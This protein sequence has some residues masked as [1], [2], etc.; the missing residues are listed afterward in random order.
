V[1]LDF[2]K[3][4]SFNSHTLVPM[5]SSESTPKDTIVFHSSPIK[6]GCVAFDSCI[7]VFCWNFNSSEVTIINGIDMNIIIICFQC[8]SHQDQS[9]FFTTCSDFFDNWIGCFVFEVN[10]IFD[11]TSSLYYIGKITILMNS[12][13]WSIDFGANSILIDV[14]LITCLLA[15]GVL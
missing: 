7:S 5:D 8:G 13:S 9:G 10:V 4:S 11:N 6:S 1:E 2:W 14:S 3:I 15:L 12:G